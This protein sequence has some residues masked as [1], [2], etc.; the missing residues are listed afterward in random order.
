MYWTSEVHEALRAN[1][2]QG[3]KEYVEVLNT[4]VRKL[5]HVITVQLMVIFFSLLLKS[6]MCA[7]RSFWSAIF[8]IF[9]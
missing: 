7:G 9:K 6:I 2:L 8:G 3:L 4:Q 1:G 5:F